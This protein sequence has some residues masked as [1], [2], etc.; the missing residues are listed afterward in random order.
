VECGSH[1]RLGPGVDCDMGMLVGW[2]M[3]FFQTELVP[4]RPEVRESQRSGNPAITHGAGVQ[5]SPKGGGPGGM[6]MQLSHVELMPDRGQEV[7]I[8]AGCGSSCSMWSWGPAQPEGQRARQ[9]GAVALQTYGMGA[10]WAGCS[11]SRLWL[12]EAFHDL[13]V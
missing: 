11:F 8:P 6:G 4:S 7:W 3:W 10:W 5:Q 9:S 12:G 1:A 2:E 13:G